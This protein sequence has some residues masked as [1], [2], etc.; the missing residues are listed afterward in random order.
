MQIEPVQ[1]A[2]RGVEVDLRP[3]VEE[4][5]EAFGQTRQRFVQLVDRIERQRRAAT[6]MIRHVLRA[7]PRRGSFKVG[8]RRRIEI[9]ALEGQPDRNVSR[10]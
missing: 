3:A 7:N 5:L 4:R 2:P 9:A 6:Q 1:R 8:I 10:Q